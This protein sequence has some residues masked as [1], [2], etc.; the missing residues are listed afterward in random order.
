MFNFQA[1]ASC[2]QAVNE[3]D[4]YI[5]KTY[6]IQL[7]ANRESSELLEKLIS[8]EILHEIVDEKDVKFLDK[9]GAA[10]EVPEMLCSSEWDIFEFSNKRN[11]KLEMK[12]IE[13]QIISSY[14][15]QELRELLV[16]IGTKCNN[17]PIW[18]INPKWELPIPLQSVLNSLPKGN[19]AH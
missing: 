17:R 10:V 18:K 6:C 4:R 13:Q 2:W 9:M 12:T 7:L 1:L 11:P 3:N 8:H 16:K 15:H 5:L 19:Y 14:N